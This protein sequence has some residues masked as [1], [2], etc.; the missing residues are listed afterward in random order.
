M[1]PALAPDV[2]AGARNWESYKTTSGVT[3]A[4]TTITPFRTVYYGTDLVDVK[5]F[6]SEDNSVTA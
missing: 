6:V 1:S 5:T 4:Q 3:G 2:G